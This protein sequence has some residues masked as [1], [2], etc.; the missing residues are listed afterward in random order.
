[1]LEATKRSWWPVMAGV[2]LLHAGLLYAI[3]QGM[4]QVP[5]AILPPQL[6]SE[7][8]LIEAAPATQVTPPVPA[9]A[10][11]PTPVKRV[12]PRK[13]PK[14]QPAQ[15]PSILHAR[16]DQAS[17]QVTPVAPQAPTPA[18]EKPVAAAPP[19]VTASGSAESESKAAQPVV[20]LPSSSASYLNNPK[21]A[22][23]LASKRM[24]EEG[25]VVLKV[26]IGVDG[27]PGEVRLHKSSGFDKLDQAALDTVKRW[28]FVPGKRGGVAEAMWFNV[29]IN[30][31]LD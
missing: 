28:R 3:H 19:T 31:V 23:P 24:G 12:E 9:P 25:R 1:M 11:K 26:Y 2:T 22:Y 7:V 4:L 10:P 16:S 6:I 27:M 8:S 20:E 17:E 30:F 14:V 15:P 18:V 13:Q 5:Q 29:P 21:P